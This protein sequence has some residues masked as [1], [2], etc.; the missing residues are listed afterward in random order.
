M[1][2]KPKHICIP[3]PY[4]TRAYP[5]SF[6]ELDVPCG[7]CL[8][9]LKRRQTDYAT[10]LYR[11]C[12]DGAPMWFITLTYRNEKLPLSISYIDFDIL[13]G[14]ELRS[15]SEVMLP[16]YYDSEVISEFRSELCAMS[17]SPKARYL[18][19]KCA[20]P[21]KSIVRRCQVTPSLNRLDVRMWL[22]KARIQYE[23]DFGKKLQFRY[24]FCGEYGPRGCRPHYHM[25]LL[26][27]HKEDMLYLVN[28][29]RD[30]FGY[31][32]FKEV[33]RVNPDGT[34]ARQIV[35]KYV[36][37]YISKGKFDADS[38][39][40]GDAQKGRLCNSKRFGTKPF[41]NEESS[42]Y[43]CFDLFGWYDTDRLC[44]DRYGKQP[45][46]PEQ[47]S[48]LVKEIVKRNHFDII[49]GDRTV[50]MPM[51]RVFK[52]HLWYVTNFYT[53][54]KSRICRE[55]FRPGIKKY[56]EGSKVLQEKD[57][58]SLF[59]RR[60]VCPKILRLVS[61]YLRD[62]ESDNLDRQFNE[63]C[64]AEHISPTF[65]AR[66]EFD[67]RLRVLKETADYSSQ[68]ADFQRKVFLSQKDRQ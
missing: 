67:E 20:S 19:M 39:I 26:D 2:T 61:D 62:R 6:I 23:R 11:E 8:S 57:K 33:P 27:L 18:S 63:F 9:C 32:Y 44:L 35:A 3:N 34:D 59:K 52:Y 16:K 38:V 40:I 51:P 13:T 36:G 15:T 43:K 37:K 17:S 53:D 54:G 50:H 42:Y 46:S 25:I 10:R 60:L 48:V 64:S 58:V 65:E 29:W 4:P 5:E 55:P 30:E 22:K 12:K 66:V 28:R 47:L 24:G 41:T 49:V 31:V 56:L 68:E 45:L 1:C 21:D 14:E 7:R